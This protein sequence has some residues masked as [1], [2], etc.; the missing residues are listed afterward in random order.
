MKDICIIA[1]KLSYSLATHGWLLILSSEKVLH[2]RQPLW[3]GRLL[4]CSLYKQ[5]FVR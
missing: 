3:S 2:K 4:S 5:F 1:N